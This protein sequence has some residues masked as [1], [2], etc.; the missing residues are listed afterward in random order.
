MFGVSENY[1]KFS[2][3]NTLFGILY[4]SLMLGIPFYGKH[5]QTFVFIVG[6]RVLTWSKY[7]NCF[8][9]NIIGN[10]SAKPS[11]TPCNTYRNKSFTRFHLSPYKKPVE[12]TSGAAS[13]SL[14]GWSASLGDDPLV[15]E[16]VFLTT[17]RTGSGQC[18]RLNILDFT[19]QKLTVSLFVVCMVLSPCD[20]NYDKQWRDD[21]LFSKGNCQKKKK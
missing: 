13:T 7:E 19:V 8:V 4:P 20:I 12:P 14:C 15:I 11:G 1:S 6:C 2:I 3:L 18:S 5:V 9:F 16:L 21:Y 17:D 10:A